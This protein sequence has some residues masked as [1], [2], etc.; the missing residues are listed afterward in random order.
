[1][2]DELDPEVIADL[3]LREYT[4][5]SRPGLSDAAFGQAIRAAAIPK[6]VDRVPCR[7]RC[8]AVVAWTEEAEDT[9]QTFNRQ[10]ARKVEAQ[11]DKTRIVFCSTCRTNGL[12][13][14]AERNRKQV[15]YIAPLIRELKNGPSADRYREILDSLRKAGHP[16]VDGLHAALL[17]KAAA[18][19]TKRVARGSL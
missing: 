17:E 4:A 8:G 9:F 10:L 6:V 5:R 13:M 14:G 7:N 16:D 2:S 19:G 3:R 11:L 12:A 18:K 15:D 1:M